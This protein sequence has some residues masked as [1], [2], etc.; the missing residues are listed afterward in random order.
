VILGRVLLL[1]VPDESSIQIGLKTLDFSL[2]LDLD[3]GGEALLE[4][5]TKKKEGRGRGSASR[6]VSEADCEDEARIRTEQIVR[7]CK[8]VERCDEEEEEKGGTSSST[9]R[10]VEL[11]ALSCCF[12]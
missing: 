4:E 3:V 11:S 6:V 10:G 5:Q 12:K 9:F 7:S 2:G 1:L 8:E